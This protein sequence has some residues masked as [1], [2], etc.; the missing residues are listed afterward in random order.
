M[1]DEAVTIAGP[2]GKLEGR[3]HLPVGGARATVVVCH[4]HPQYGGDM[5]SNVVM[6]LV[7][8]AVKSGVLALRFNFR[9][10]G[11][12]EGS[13]DNGAGEQDD[14]KA[15]LAYMAGRPE[16]GDD[17]LLAGYSFGAMTAALA[18]GPN[19]RALALV[20]PPLN[21]PE[22]IRPALAAYPGPVLLAAGDSDHV[23]PATALRELGQG[24]GARATVHVTQG[25]DH[26]WWGFEPELARVASA[27]FAAALQ[28]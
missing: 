5:N 3:L 24:L 28:G 8:A 9:G 13:Y 4:P 10:V 25:T 23:C 26:F 17:L 27:F 21:A 18:V 14:V 12:S 16:A 20:A 19:V 7:E 15:A 11:S 22:R 1:K 6:A 2:A